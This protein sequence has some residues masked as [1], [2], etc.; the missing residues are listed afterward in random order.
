MLL[1]AA[2]GHHGSIYPVADGYSWAKGNSRHWAVDPGLVG[3]AGEVVHVMSAGLQATKGGTVVGELLH[4]AQRA[5]TL[6]HVGTAQLHMSWWVEGGGTN[7][8]HPLF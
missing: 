7:T 4:L 2:A 3:E 5:S 6:T 1:A 8:G